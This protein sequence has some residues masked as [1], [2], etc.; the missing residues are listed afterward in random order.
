MKL[1]FILCLL[2][3]LTLLTVTCA[4]QGA[5]GDDFW[6]LAPDPGYTEEEAEI[7]AAVSEVVQALEERL[8]LGDDYT[9]INWAIDEGRATL[10]IGV[11]NEENV[12]KAAEACGDPRVDVVYDEIEWIRIDG[13]DYNDIQLGQ[14]SEK[15][16]WELP[17]KLNSQDYADIV[18][19]APGKVTIWAV[20]EGK[21]RTAVKA[22]KEPLVE[23]TYRKA[24]F[25]KF[26]MDRVMKTVQNLDCVKQNPEKVTEIIS[27]PDGV[28]IRLDKNIP[29]LYRWLRTYRYK[30]VVVE[31]EV[32][33]KL[34]PGIAVY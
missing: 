8:V 17:E 23:V 9:Y 34:N 15:M 29:E 33:T 16:C 13:K 6:G 30:E 7:A 19:Y 11:A 31:C 28:H 3:T 14:A 32:Y 10:H 12:R 2:L 5:E 25:S 20:N 27:S 4:A 26:R 22:Y 21:V 18:S 1:R 24:R